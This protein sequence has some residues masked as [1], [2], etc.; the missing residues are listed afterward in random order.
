MCAEG[1][2]WSWFAAHPEYQLS[3]KKAVIR[4]F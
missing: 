1:V 4:P 2:Q 3:Y